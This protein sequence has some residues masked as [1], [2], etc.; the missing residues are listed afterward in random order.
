MTDP[1]ISVEGVVR[2]FGKGPVLDGVE[3]SVPRGELLA[4]IG[5]SGVGKSTLLSIMDGLLR[6][7]SGSVTVMGERL[8]FD[9]EADLEVRR[10][11]SLVSQSPV[12]FRNTVRYNVQYPLVLRDTVD[13]ARVD[14][15]LERVRMLEMADQPAPTLSGGELQRMAFA[16]AIVYRPA[17]L[18]LDE[19]TSHLDPYNIK[20]LEEGVRWYIEEGGTVVMVTHNLFQAKRI[21]SSTAFLLDGAMVESGPTDEV[22]NDPVDERTRAFVCGEMVF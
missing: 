15:A 2:S 17:L 21:S 9:T 7:D 12:A 4:I 22:F 20:V 14:E 10:R 1:V 8:T 18:L 19:F 3:L 11:M 13:T 16:R 5:P 6:P